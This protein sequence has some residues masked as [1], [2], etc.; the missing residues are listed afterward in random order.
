MSDY[1]ITETKPI[2]TKTGTKMSKAILVDSQ[3]QEYQNV[4]LF[5]PYTENKV[6]D[7]IKGSL[8]SNDYNGKTGWKFKGRDDN[9]HIQEK[10]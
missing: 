9:D 8:D 6:A 10:G 7:I 2:T 5:T 3:G 4:T 1:K